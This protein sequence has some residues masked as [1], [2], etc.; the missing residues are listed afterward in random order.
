MNLLQTLTRLAEEL[1][2]A[3]NVRVESD[4]VAIEFERNGV[5]YSTGVSMDDTADEIESAIR[6]VLE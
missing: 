3:I 2:C 5:N 1:G 6:E 4:L